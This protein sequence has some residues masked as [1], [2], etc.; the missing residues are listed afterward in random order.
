[1]NVPKTKSLVIMNEAKKMTD[2]Q[3]IGEYLF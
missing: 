3:E 2:F 1:M